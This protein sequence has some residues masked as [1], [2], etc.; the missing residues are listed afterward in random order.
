M[1]GDPSL[2]ITGSGIDIEAL[3]KAGQKAVNEYDAK[4]VENIFAQINAENKDNPNSMMGL[5][6]EKS[7]EN[8]ATKTT[9]NAS[10]GETTETSAKA[11]PEKTP[12]QTG[13]ITNN[14]DPELLKNAPKPNITI[15]GEEKNAAIVVDLSENRLYRYTDKG[16]AFEVYSIASGKKSTPT[17]T[18]LR[19][20]ANIETYPYDKAPKATKRHQNPKPYGPNILILNQIDPATGEDLGSNGEFI[21]GNNNSKS[22]GTYA[23]HGCMRMDNDVIKQLAKE[24]KRGSYVIIQE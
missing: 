7:N 19:K 24:V 10:K 1:G 6:L 16:E 13:K 20:V 23:S 4:Q 11:V 22:I 8:A 2:S 21:H 17:H 14:K 3:V 5:T 12:T 9:E 15:A 18:G